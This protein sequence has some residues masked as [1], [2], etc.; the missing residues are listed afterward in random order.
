MLLLQD[1]WCDLYCAR[2]SPGGVWLVPLML[3]REE[4]WTAFLLLNLPSRNIKKWQTSMVCFIFYFVI[5]IGFMPS[6]LFLT[7]IY[8]FST[9]VLRRYPHLSQASFG[10]IVNSFLGEKPNVI[11]TVDVSLTLPTWKLILLRG[12]LLVIR[13]VSFLFQ[14]VQDSSESETEWAAST[15]SPTS[16]FYVFW[17][18]FYEMSHSLQLKTF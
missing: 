4:W 8:L 12:F 3:A 9:F 5:K 10:A 1:A 15:L 11:Q 18:I 17:L 16:G 2:L 13:L 6:V 14:Y 7:L